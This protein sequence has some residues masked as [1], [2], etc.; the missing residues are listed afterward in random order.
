MSGKKQQTYV[1]TLQDGKEKSVRADELC[2]PDENGEYYVL[3]LEGQI[4]GKYLEGAVKGWHIKQPGS[5]SGL[6]S[7]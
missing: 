3:K 6:V 4:V 7:R 5:G 2:E 1:I